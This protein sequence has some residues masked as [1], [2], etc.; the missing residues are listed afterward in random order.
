M[1]QWFII[2]RQRCSASDS[3]FWLSWTSENLFWTVAVQ[4]SCTFVSIFV[5]FFLDDFTKTQ[6]NLLYD[7]L[8]ILAHLWKKVTANF[9]DLFY[10]I[11][12]RILLIIIFDI[13]H[14]LDKICII[15][16]IFL[17]YTSSNAPE[18]FVLSIK[19]RTLT[20]H[21]VHFQNS[22]HFWRTAL[23]RE[24]YVV[25]RNF[26]RLRVFLSFKL[27]QLKPHC[28]QQTDNHSNVRFWFCLQLKHTK[29]TETVRWI[30]TI[31]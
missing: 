1:W 8:F 10:V 3:Y 7:H 4:R 31:I 30:D 11:L 26:I 25:G 15:K 2:S 22:L 28:F 19:I 13:H 6:H 14:R 21:I 23:H 18:R 16:V 20:D 24:C 27:F 12:K 29:W 5:G 9:F 17:S